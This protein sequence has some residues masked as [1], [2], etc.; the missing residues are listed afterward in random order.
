MTTSNVPEPGPDTAVP[1]ARA[2]RR[3]MFYDDASG[4]S[5]YAVSAGFYAL[6]ILAVLL[7]AR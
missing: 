3:R 7:F 5:V 6:L 1:S 2:E 4:V